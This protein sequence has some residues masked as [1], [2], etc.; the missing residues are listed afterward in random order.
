MDVL[1]AWRD[2][3]GAENVLTDAATL[4]AAQTATFAT[5]QRVLA[6]IRPSDRTEV[7][8]CLKIA[9]RY[10]TPVY[11]VSCGKNWGLGSRV[12]VRD[13][14]AIIDLSRLNRILDYNEKLA[15][16]TVEPGVTFRQISQYLRTAKSNL[17]VSVIGG[18]P[19]ASAIANTLERGDGIGPYGDRVNYV[20]GFEVVLPTG[21]CIHT[22]L[23]RFANA[24]ATPVSRWGVGPYLDGIFTQSNL[25]IVTQMTIWLTP[26]PNYFQS[27][28]CAIKDSSR[29]AP[30]VDRIQTLMLQG[31]LKENCFCFWNAYKVLAKEGRY[32][33]KVMGGKTPLCLKELKGYEPWVG[34][35][36]LY[37]A[38]REQGLAERKLIEQALE[39]LVD[40]LMFVD[41]DQDSNLLQDNLDLGV[42]S[43]A[44][45]KSTYWRKKSQIPFQMNPDRDNCGV[46][47]LCPLFPFDGE[48]IVEILPAI[49]STIK[50]AQFEPNLAMS[51]TTAR[52]IRMFIAIMYDRTVAGEDQR[53]AECHDQLLQQLLEA[54]YFPYRLGIH[55]MNSL[56]P[57]QDDYGKLM[58]V[59]KQGLDPNN[60]LAPGRYDFQGDW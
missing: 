13:N 34:S 23:G 55:S 11:P 60:I 52:N 2:L 27:F 59:L 31:I 25:G 19:D 56:P 29:L 7:Q 50:A 51:C 28:S 16:I 48:Q 24:K 5:T 32:P 42:P 38:S 37:S 43:D 57:A 46:L 17:F 22:G 4:C 47:W 36:T 15:Y 35:G 33:W 14:C 40:Q 49:A 6:V 12:P 9:N 58:S 8:E 10:Q 20:C 45:I 54:G 41:R 26:I 21:E 30:L 1:K 53:A 39:P 44:N 3:L 18:S